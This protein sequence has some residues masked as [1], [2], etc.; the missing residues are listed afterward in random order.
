[1]MEICLS[2]EVIFLALRED[3]EDFE[4]YT[5]VLGKLVQK[6]KQII[7]KLR[8]W[9]Q[10]ALQTLILLKKTQPRRIASL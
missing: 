10:V 3:G 4:E 8:A 9:R 2:P 7:S 6:Y 5:F 1:M